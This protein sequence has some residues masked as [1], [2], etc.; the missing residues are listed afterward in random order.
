MTLRL[1]SIPARD[2]AALTKTFGPSAAHVEIVEQSRFAKLHRALATT[3]R[4][5]I[6]LACDVDCFL[7]DPDLMLHEY[8]HVIAQWNAGQLSVAKYLW[9]S[10]KRGYRN[11]RFEVAACQ[12]ARA[13]AAE[14]KRLRDAA[15]QS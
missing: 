1:V 2:L 7:R 12:F 3:R 13:H 4:N 14:F 10:L 11:N 9:E 8:Y 6:Y 5:R 15:A